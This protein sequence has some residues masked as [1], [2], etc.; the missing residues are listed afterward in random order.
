MMALDAGMAQRRPKKKVPPEDELRVP[1]MPRT[2]ETTAKSNDTATQTKKLA[3]IT[4][5]QTNTRA[6]ERSSEKT[7]RSTQT[8]SYY[9]DTGRGFSG[10][11]RSFSD[12]VPKPPES[13]LRISPTPKTKRTEA[14]KETYIAQAYPEESARQQIRKSPS[15]AYTKA[16]TTIRGG[17]EPDYIK[18][19]LWNMAYDLT[20]DER[21]TLYH[22]YVTLPKERGDPYATVDPTEAAWERD[23]ARRKDAM[24][25][26][27]GNRVI[28]GISSDYNESAANDY[29]IP[30][31]DLEAAAKRS[32]SRAVYKRSYEL[33][34][35]S[36]MMTADRELA[37]LQAQYD[38]QQ[39]QYQTLRAIASESGNY[40]DERIARDKLKALQTQI[41]KT[42]KRKDVLLDIHS[43]LE[44]GIELP[45]TWSDDLSAIPTE[46][47]AFLARPD[48]YYS[49]VT[50]SKGYDLNSQPDKSIAKD[51]WEYAYINNLFGARASER[52]INADAASEYRFLSADEVGIYNYL[53]KTEGKASAS[54][55]LS[56][57]A[58]VINQRYG[59]NMYNNLDDINKAIFWLPQGLD[60]FFTGVRQL[61]S[62]DALPTSPIQVAGAMVRQDVYDQSKVGGFLYD[63]GTSTSAMLPALAISAIAGPQA[64]AAVMG[65][66][67]A[68][69][70]YKQKLDEGWTK[71]QASAYATLIGV[72]EATLQNL[73]GGINTLGGEKLLTGK[74]LDGLLTATSQID[75]GFVRF[76]AEY[77][78]RLAI[79][80][81]PEAFEEGAQGIL[82]AVFTHVITGEELNIDWGE[83][84]YEAL[85]GFVTSVI[86]NAPE[87]Y[88]NTQSDT[89]LANTGEVGYTD[90]SED[91]TSEQLI[92]E[93][94]ENNIKFTKEKI[95]FITKDQTGQ[96]VWLEKGNS[97]GGLEHITIRHADDFLSK[98]GVEESSIP[99]Y[100]KSVFQTG[101]IEYSRISRN[102]GGFEKLYK[103]NGQY[104]LLSG[105]GENG[106]I[107]SAY[108]IGDAEAMKLIGRYKK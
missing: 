102:N 29:R 57:M 79:K 70:A 23:R 35:Q 50:L 63:V 60:R 20:P 18:D 103:Y 89:A 92:R 11:G 28:H 83:V 22:D 41:D 10:G 56:W 55:Y 15:A 37:A 62:S 9:A 74:A 26:I 67:S 82:D 107:V 16:E 39:K 90:N 30:T 72:S 45:F 86:L 68:G 61:T 3:D 75:N 88:A 48:V 77:G 49:T 64:G 31:E 78:G 99:A 36:G 12:S 24:K 46:Q 93:L 34:N 27:T 80:G 13:E 4:P 52:A 91:F 25:T 81:M 71:E 104:Y 105:I 66:S 95:V 54:K 59:E 87:E 94:E 98:N 14:E 33:R 32:N 42:Q 85:A 65:A 2:N 51:D 5:P 8:L 1:P 97:S 58:T 7:P 44:R 17:K 40:A 100:L 6:L 108:P 101:E 96:T 53:Y 19:Y 84:A 73:I 76:I 21:D 69:N 43:M 106:F 38:E 47:L